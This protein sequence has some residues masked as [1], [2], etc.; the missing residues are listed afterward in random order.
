MARWLS[1]H[2]KDMWIR[3]VPGPRPDPTREDALREIRGFLD[4]LKTVR[5]VEILPY[6]TLGLFKWDNLGIDYP[7]AGVPTPTDEQVRRAEELLGIPHPDE[8]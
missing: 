8:T 4:S 7:L 2:G 5:R 6:H 1:D 3:H